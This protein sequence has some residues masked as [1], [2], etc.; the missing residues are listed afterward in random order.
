MHRRRYKS[1]FPWFGDNDSRSGTVAEPS[2]G[3]F[4]S[5]IR[6][7]LAGIWKIANDVI[8]RR[9]L[10]LQQNT[11]GLTDQRR[12]DQRFDWLQGG[13]PQGMRGADLSR[14][15]RDS[16]DRHIFAQAQAVHIP[17]GAKAE[18]CASYPTHRIW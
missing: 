2:I 12:N 1:A 16:C 4:D 8:L 13:F 10:M 5:N 7:S 3:D 15:R 11:P 14:H 9:E 17:V 18:A 6:L